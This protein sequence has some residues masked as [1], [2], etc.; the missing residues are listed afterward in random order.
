MI[1]VS[2]SGWMGEE[3]D[4]FVDIKEGLVYYFVYLYN[5][6]KVSPVQFYV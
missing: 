6:I 4:D 1:Q 2:F 5:T 3:S